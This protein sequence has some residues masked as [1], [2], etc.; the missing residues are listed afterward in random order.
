VPVEAP[1]LP[2]QKTKGW[3]FTD[4][5]DLDI[6]GYGVADAEIEGIT[7]AAVKGEPL[8]MPLAEAAESFPELVNP[9]LGSLVPD[10]DPFVARNTSA[11][12][13]GLFVHVPAGT[14]LADPV[15][16][17]ARQA[18]EGSSLHWRALIVLE[19]G[20]EAE[21]WET[22]ESASPELDAL[23][24]GVVELVVATPR[25]TGSPSGSAPA[26]AR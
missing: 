17:L 13:Q 5:S 16:L 10:E 14:K 26:A 21:V 9:H 6:D 15:R 19:E 11:W 25:S 23:F 18:Q 7:G 20:A 1:P 2:D 22:Y 12:K 3:E 24:N 8:V 4:L